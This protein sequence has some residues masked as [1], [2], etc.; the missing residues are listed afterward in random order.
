MAQTILL[1]CHLPHQDLL[2]VGVKNA[3]INFYWLTSS[4]TQWT[5]SQN[6]TLRFCIWIRK[7]SGWLVCLKGFSKASWKNNKEHYCT[8]KRRKSQKGTFSF[9]TFAGIN[10][11][12][13]SSIGH[14][15]APII[16][17]WGSTGITLWQRWR[18]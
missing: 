18:K 14:F 1:Q 3:C 5:K 17:W 11:I 12:S 10:S 16:N 7:R 15:K 6:F 4:P 13:K 9:A 2:S 8:R